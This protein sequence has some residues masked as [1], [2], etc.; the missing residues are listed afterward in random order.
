MAVRFYIFFR[1]PH[2]GEFLSAPRL[3]FG[4][5]ENALEVVGSPLSNLNNPLVKNAARDASALVGQS[6]LSVLEV[7]K[8]LLDRI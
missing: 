1:V 8:S 2:V 5:S 6:E 3:R 4:C 7:Y